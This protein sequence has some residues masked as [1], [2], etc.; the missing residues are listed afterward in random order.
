MEGIWTVNNNIAIS[1]RINFKRSHYN[2][3]ASKKADSF[4]KISLFYVNLD[5]KTCSEY[6]ADCIKFDNSHFKNGYHFID[7]YAFTNAKKVPIEEESNSVQLKHIMSLA[8]DLEAK[9]SRNP[10]SSSKDMEY[11]VIRSDSVSFDLRVPVS[12]KYCVDEFPNINSITF[13]V[14]ESLDNFS[15]K[16]YLISNLSPN[17]PVE[18]NFIKPSN[19]CFSNQKNYLSYFIFTTCKNL[20]QEKLNVTGIKL[21]LKI[22]SN[23]ILSKNSKA[24]LEICKLWNLHHLEINLCFENGSSFITIPS[25]SP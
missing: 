6:H 15:D 9:N 21:E 20:W 24:N 19:H 16:N 1:T 25:C 18:L 4:D 2:I 5:T 23:G 7:N 22:D 3:E 14:D 12:T 17:L 10:F 13:V 8:G 11:T